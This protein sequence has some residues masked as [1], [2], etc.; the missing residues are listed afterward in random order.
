MPSPLPTPTP[1]AGAVLLGGP[2]SDLSQHTPSGREV[3]EA[4]AE[5]EEQEEETVAGLQATHAAR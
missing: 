3:Q 4:S 1:A 2:A 5:E